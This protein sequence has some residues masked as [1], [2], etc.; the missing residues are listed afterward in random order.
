VNDQNN[1]V[2]EDE[3]VNKVPTPKEQHTFVFK[4]YNRAQARRFEYLGVKYERIKRTPAVNETKREFRTYRRELAMAHGS[5]TGRLK[6]K[7][8]DREKAPARNQEFLM[9]LNEGH[10]FEIDEVIKMGYSK[11]TAKVITEKTDE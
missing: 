9:L 8:I 6:K 10:K 5:T 2:V 1:L 7:H 4:A 11:A 3:E